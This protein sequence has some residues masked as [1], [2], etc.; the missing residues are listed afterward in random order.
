MTIG[1]VVSGM[2]AS[3]FTEAKER[4]KALPN[5]IKYAKNVKD[6][7]S[8]LTW[9]LESDMGGGRGSMKD[10]PLSMLGQESTN[11]CSTKV[12]MALQEIVDFCDDPNG[13]EN[14]ESLAMGLARLLPAARAALNVPPAQEVEG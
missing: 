7:P 2:E 3:S 1:I 9:S 6:K 8:E 12:E 11:P 4:M 5:F 14:P 13:S 10:E